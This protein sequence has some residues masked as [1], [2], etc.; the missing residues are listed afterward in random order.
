MVLNRFLLLYFIVFVSCITYKNQKQFY[1]SKVISFNTSSSTRKSLEYLPDSV[2]FVLDEKLS[3]YEEKRPS[4]F[5]LDTIFGSVSYVKYN[6]F[7]DFDSI[8]KVKNLDEFF[9][10]HIESKKII[11]KA[12][13]KNHFMHIS[14]TNTDNNKN[15]VFL[16][17][18]KTTKAIYKIDTLKNKNEVTDIVLNLIFYKKSNIKWIMYDK[19]VIDDYFENTIDCVNAFECKSYNSPVI[20]ISSSRDW[21]SNGWKKEYLIIP[22]DDKKEQINYLKIE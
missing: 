17:R 19:I 18:N 10:N 22:S 6:G 3:E 7:Y 14:C 1:Y 20:Y 11:E 21:M 12:K 13:D 2:A 5:Y 9:L 8:K 16:D 4:G 15:E